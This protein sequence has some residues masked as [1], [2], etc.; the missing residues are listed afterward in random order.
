[1][2]KCIIWSK[3]QAKT[4]FGSLCP[5]EYDKLYAKIC[6]NLLKATYDNSKENQN[7]KIITKLLYLIS[8]ELK[9]CVVPENTSMDHVLKQ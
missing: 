1:M 8:I 3:I 9:N 7:Q 5:P 4:G 6:I 2:N